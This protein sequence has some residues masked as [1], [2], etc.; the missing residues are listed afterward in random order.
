MWVVSIPDYWSVRWPSGKGLVR[1]A[2][3]YAMLIT[4][5]AEVGYKLVTS[6]LIFVFQP[7][8]MICLIQV[9][10]VSVQNHFQ[11]TVLFIR[12]FPGD[13]LLR[14]AGF[15]SWALFAPKLG[16]FCPK[17]RL[18]SPLSFWSF[19]AAIEDNLNCVM[20]KI[21]IWLHANV[22]AIVMPFLSR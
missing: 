18:F 11:C 8:H 1:Y 15:W 22:T 9:L 7:C 21:T 13:C 14:I 3:F 5:V 2:L 6:Q 12:H 19:T 4:W 17:V 20:Q 16:Y 10:S